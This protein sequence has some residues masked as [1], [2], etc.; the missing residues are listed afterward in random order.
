MLFWLLA[1]CSCRKPVE[2]SAGDC[3]ALSDSLQRVHAGEEVAGVAVED[4]RVQVVVA[5][6]FDAPKGFEEEL[7]AG[8]LTQGWVLTSQLCVLADS[9]GVTEVRPPERASPK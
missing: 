6:D 4:G 5:G 7:R 2:A 1:S 9:P 3:S 8:G